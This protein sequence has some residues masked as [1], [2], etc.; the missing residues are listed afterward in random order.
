MTGTRYEFSGQE[1]ASRYL[2]HG[3]VR[4]EGKPIYVVSVRAARNSYEIGYCRIPYNGEDGERRCDLSDPAL[5][6]TPIP[7]GFVNYLSLNQCAALRRNP[8]RDWKVGLCG[9]NASL[10]MLGQG[11]RGWQGVD[12]R[13]LTGPDF[14]NTYMRRYPS[15]TESLQRMARVRDT[16]EVSHAVA[17]SYRFAVNPALHLYHLYTCRAPVGEVRED[18]ASAILSPKFAYLREA[19]AQDGIHAD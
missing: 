7:L 12:G 8:V 6:L 2:R 15:L 14:Y 4:Y 10:F 16:E 18:G 9:N 17:F 11:E 1:H 19:L 5:D 13:I 3:V